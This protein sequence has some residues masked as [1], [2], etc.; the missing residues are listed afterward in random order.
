MSVRAAAEL[1]GIP[2][3]TLGD[4]ISGRV[5]PGTASGAVRY[6]ADSE[7]EELA[8]FIVGCASIGY[9]KTIRDILAIVQSILASRGVHRIVTYG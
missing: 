5:L 4:R 1:Y 3:S 9:P 7:E 8:E 6:L 2:K